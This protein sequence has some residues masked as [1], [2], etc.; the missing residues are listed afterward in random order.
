MTNGGGDTAMFKSCTDINNQNP[1][2]YTSNLQIKA[3]P[4]DHSSSL[5]KD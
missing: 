2:S 3:E 5:G 4:H 1:N